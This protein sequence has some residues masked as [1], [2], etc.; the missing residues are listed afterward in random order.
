MEPRNTHHGALFTDFPP[1]AIAPL[2]LKTQCQLVRMRLSLKIWVNSLVCPTSVLMGSRTLWWP[3]EQWR[4]AA[5]PLLKSRPAPSGGETWH[6]GTTSAILRNWRLFFLQPNHTAPPI[7]PSAHNSSQ[8]LL[9]FLLCCSNRNP[10]KRWLER[11]NQQSLIC[12]LFFKM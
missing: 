9:P 4:P 11:N 6:L 12:N 7:D 10:G 5:V 1:L 8:F 2:G 3:L